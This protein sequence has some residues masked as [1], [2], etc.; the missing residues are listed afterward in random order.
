LDFGRIIASGTPKDVQAN[1]AVQTAYLGA[2]TSHVEGA[3]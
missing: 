2:D 1:P 3:A